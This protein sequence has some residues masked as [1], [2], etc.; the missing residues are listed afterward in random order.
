MGPGPWVSL[1]R[2]W[3][4]AEAAGRGSGPAPPFTSRWISPC[5]DVL[6]CEIRIMIMVALRETFAKGTNYRHIWPGDHVTT[7]SHRYPAR[8]P[9]IQLC[10]WDLLTFKR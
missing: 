5:L 1:V 4:C 3:G 9:E 10:I 7:V 8:G 6:G 2:D